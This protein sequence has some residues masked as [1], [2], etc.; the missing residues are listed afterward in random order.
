MINNKTFIKG[1]F[2]CLP[3]VLLFTLVACKENK[4]VEKKF[5]EIISELESYKLEASFETYFEN[6]SKECNVLV[7]YMSPNYYRVELTN[8]VGKEKQIM[9]KNDKG[10][11]IILPSINKTF[12]ITSDW[13]EC[14][15][16]PYLLHS[17]SKDIVTSEDIITKT[18]NGN[19]ALELKVKLFDNTEPVKEKIVFDQK[20]KLP[21][22]IYIY[23]TNNSLF[24]HVSIKSIEKNPKLSNDIFV[25]DNTI[26]SSRLDYIETPIEFDR[27]ITYPTFCPVNTKLYQ[28][29]ILGDETDKRAVMKFN[30]DSSFTLVQAYTKETET[31]KNEYFTGDIC[32]MAGSFGLVAN[33]TIKFYSNGVEYI[34]ASDNTSLVDLLM[35]GESL[36]DS[37]IK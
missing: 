37:D 2:F 27:S 8:N 16:Q 23:R 32:V 4:V 20:T 5:P 6:G 7:Y 1:L 30:G 36:G 29:I 11:F 19:T 35:I 22:D 14:T 12:K 34:I 10:V 9:I 17:L 26:T 15:N 25:V 31:L 24:N 33:N 13:P 28:E 3:L 21:K 18:E